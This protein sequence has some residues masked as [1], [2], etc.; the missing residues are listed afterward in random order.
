M[1]EQ[2]FKSIPATKEM[3]LIQNQIYTPA[4]SH[5]LTIEDGSVYQEKAPMLELFLGPNW[6]NILD[7]SFQMMHITP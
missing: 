4:L 1:Q 7:T 3:H 6:L 2:K 5:R